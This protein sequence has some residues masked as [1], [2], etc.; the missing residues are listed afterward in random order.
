MEQEF[1][2]T[3]FLK[4]LEPAIRLMCT[5]LSDYAVLLNMF[6]HDFLMFIVMVLFFVVVFVCLFVIVQGF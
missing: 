6:F 2:G 1:S 4:S 5:V 3:F